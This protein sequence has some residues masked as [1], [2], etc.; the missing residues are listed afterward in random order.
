LVTAPNFSVNKKSGMVLVAVLWIVAALS[1]I[2]TGMIQ[3]VRA[4]VKLVS[5]ASQIAQGGAS[6][7]A[8]IAAVLQSLSA[9]SALQ[10]SSTLTDV[11]F[12]GLSISVRAMPLNGLI[13]LNT[14]SPVLLEKLFLVAGELPASQASAMAEMV[15]VERTRPDPQGRAQPLESVE[16]LLRITAMD[17]DTYAKVANLVTTDAR[18]S[19]RVNVGAAPLG[20]LRVLAGGN[21][22]VA[23]RIYQGREAGAVGQ[24]TSALDSA[25][26]DNAPSRRYLVQ[27]R[28]PLPDGAWLLVSRWV[29]M[30][31]GKAD[32]LPW[33]VFHAENLL[34][35]ASDL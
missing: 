13:D 7:G 5:A 1:V 9:P 22:E 29:D 11:Q 27:A 18:G 10:S 33:R 28:V 24:D 34:E 8:A 35:P 20:V 31:S 12:Q 3:S 26:V 2:V 6:G 14:A 25:L 15:R 4:E 16:D 23:Q 17:Y 21:V 19:G 30:N 32:G